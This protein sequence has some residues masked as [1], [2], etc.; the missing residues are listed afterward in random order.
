VCG[1]EGGGGGKKERIDLR[2]AGISRLRELS[3]GIRN[4]QGA[5]SG[6]S[7]I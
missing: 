7:C 5:T 4:G 2:E 1:G 3:E 6:D